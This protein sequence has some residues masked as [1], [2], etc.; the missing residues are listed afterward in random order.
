MKII[1]QLDIDLSLVPVQLR[2]FSPLEVIRRCV[3]EHSTLYREEQGS[4]NS[5]LGWLTATEILKLARLLHA[6]DQEI[7]SIRIEMVAKAIQTD[8]FTTA[9]SYCKQLMRENVSSA[10]PHIV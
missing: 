6:T 4:F 10:W 5:F 9:Y 7:L 8:D 1:A 3:D 2:N